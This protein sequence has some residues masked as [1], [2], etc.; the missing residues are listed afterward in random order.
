MKSF[1]TVFSLMLHVA[2]SMQA[3]AL[4]GSDSSPSHD[5]IAGASSNHLPSRFLDVDEMRDFVTLECNRGIEAA[6]CTFSLLGLVLMLR[7]ALSFPVD[8]ASLWNTR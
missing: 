3:V 8:N 5:A 2:T 4:R 1:L 7:S 6:V